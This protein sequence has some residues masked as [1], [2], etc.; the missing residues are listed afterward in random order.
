MA[1]KISKTSQCQGFFKE[2]VKFAKQY[3]EYYFEFF[4]KDCPYNLNFELSEKLPYRLL[5]EK[6]GWGSKQGLLDNLNKL[7]GLANHNEKKKMK[8]TYGFVTG[9][10]IRADWLS[11][12]SYNLDFPDI[13]KEKF[14]HELK[15][16]LEK[17]IKFKGLKEF[18]QE[19]F[20]ST[21]NLLIKIPTGEGK[22]EAALLWAINN[23]KNKYTRVIYTM[24]TQVTSNAMYKRLKSYFGDENVGICSWSGLNYS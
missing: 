21:D 14:M 13:N 2:T 11:S 7:L 17:G 3:R 12:G 8:E 5:R 24:P 4:Q 9:N 19:S 23:L 16:Y 22:T 18:Q 10:L 15:N 20:E 1:L 6:I